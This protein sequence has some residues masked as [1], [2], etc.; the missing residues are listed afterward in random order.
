MAEGNHNIC[1]SHMQVKEEADEE[2]LYIDVDVVGIDVVKFI[3]MSENHDSV[4]VKRI[5]ENSV[6]MEDLNDSSVQI[7]EEISSTS[8][9]DRENVEAG[10]D[11]LLSGINDC[12]VQM[13]ETKNK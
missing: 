11:R 4:Q 12:S 3:R 1:D 13:D 8:E 5:N 7:V 9:D 6:R 2:R 10:E